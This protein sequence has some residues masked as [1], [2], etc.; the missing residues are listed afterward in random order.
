MNS[1]PN[2][3]VHLSSALFQKE[4]KLQAQHDTVCKIKHVLS[5]KFLDIS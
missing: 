4:T 2:S 5:Q 3:A 1:P